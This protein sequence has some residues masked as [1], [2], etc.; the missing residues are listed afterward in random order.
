MPVH[1]FQ[2]NRPKQ[3]R[4]AARHLNR[5]YMAHTPLNLYLYHAH[6]AIGLFAAV[7]KQRI[8]LP[9]FYQIEPFHNFRRQTQLSSARVHNRIADDVFTLLFDGKKAVLPVSQ[10]DLNAENAH[11]N[12]PF[13]ATYASP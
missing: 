3:N 10:L 6:D 8:Y 9:Y 12:T 13:V 11:S 4:R 1:L 5:L 7:G 2:R